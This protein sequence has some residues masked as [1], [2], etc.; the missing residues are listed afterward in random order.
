MAN[1]QGLCVACHNRKTA[2]ESA[3]ARQVAAF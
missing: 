2:I 3:N 1:L